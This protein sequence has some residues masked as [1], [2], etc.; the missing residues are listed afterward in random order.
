M[1]LKL[2]QLFL[3]ILF[4]IQLR[5]AGN[6]LTFDEKII[7][8][9]SGSCDDKLLSLFNIS[10]KD[11]G[12]KKPYKASS[13]AREYCRNN[14]I[15]CCSGEEIQTVVQKYEASNNKLKQLFEPIEEMLTLF[16]G[17]KFEQ[18]F[19]DFAKTD[20]Y[21]ENQ[22]QKYVSFKN[23]ADPHFDFN[24]E[25][26]E[27]INRIS[28]LIKNLRS[29]LAYF[30]KR[31]NWFFGNL[32]CS[33][34]SPQEQKYMELTDKTFKLKA[35]TNTCIELLNLKSFEIDLA[36]IYQ[37][38]LRPVA[39][40]A[41][42]IA[43]EGSSNDN[44]PDR[45]ISM[46]VDELLKLIGVNENCLNKLD[47]LDEDCKQVCQRSLSEYS[48]PFKLIDFYVSS[49][50]FYFPLLTGMEAEE[51]YVDR[52]SIAYLKKFPNS[53]RFFEKLYAFENEETGS[54]NLEIKE[55]GVRVFSNQWSKKF[56]EITHP[57]EE[58]TK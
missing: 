18:T 49:L 42:C 3:T 35:D 24:L 20:E 13:S 45:L 32:I 21:T 36:V 22:C 23:E 48:V 51:Y 57:I 2:N 46:D 54:I 17:K 41:A 7:P 26:S 16:I 11:Y 34:C 52:K 25:D 56:S 12:V 50:E 37:T 53:S 9:E 31:Q 15:S 44:I 40:V 33:V 30:I 8:A 5:L 55:N 47:S 58:I 28:E 4:L 29:D 14:K 10:P 6:R 38:F 43:R 1:T 19:L 27:H 39:N